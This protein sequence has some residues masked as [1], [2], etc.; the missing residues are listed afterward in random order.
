MHYYL[1]FASVF[2]INR[3][4]EEVDDTRSKAILCELCQKHLL[5]VFVWNIANHK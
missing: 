4:V 1:N 2:E 5:R 3:Q